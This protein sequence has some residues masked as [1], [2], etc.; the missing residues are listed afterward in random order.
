MQ[1][2]ASIYRYTSFSPRISASNSWPNFNNQNQFLGL[3][4][5]LATIRPVFKFFSPQLI[6]FPQFFLP[7]VF[8]PTLEKRVSFLLYSPTGTNA[9]S[10]KIFFNA[11]KSEQKKYCLK[12]NSEIIFLSAADYRCDPYILHIH[13]SFAKLI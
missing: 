11:T 1:I 2:I 4:Q 10:Y 13:R 6:F 5:L 7:L 9:I 12:I 8:T 3:Q